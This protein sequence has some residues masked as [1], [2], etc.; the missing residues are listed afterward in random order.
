MT[1]GSE[2]KT[3]SY[4]FNLIVSIILVNKSKLTIRNGSFCPKQNI[5]TGNIFIAVNGK[6]ITCILYIGDLVDASA[7][8]RPVLRTMKALLI[9]VTVP[10]S[11]V[12]MTL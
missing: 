6:N 2:I 1:G 12:A 11:D 4:V 8:V 3:G 5:S 7:T 9:N 10:A